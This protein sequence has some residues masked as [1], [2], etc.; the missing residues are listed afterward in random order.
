MQ[1]RAPL[2]RITLVTPSRT[3]HANSSRRSLGTS[4]VEFGRSA[5]ISA[6]ASAVRARGQLAGQGQLAI[7]LHCASYVGERV[8]GEPF[9]VGDLGLRAGGVDVEQALGELRLDRDHGQRVPEDVV[10]VA[11]EPVALLGDRE[12][13]V[14][15]V[16]TISWALRVSICWIPQ[17]ATVA[18][19]MLSRRPGSGSHPGTTKPAR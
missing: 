7:A 4:S 13:A 10:E 17:T 15:V 6:A 12:P 16:A 9:Q 2:C 19:S 5:S 1:R 3:V 14:L 11:G 18:A 8:A